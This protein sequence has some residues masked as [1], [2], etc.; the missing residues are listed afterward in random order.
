LSLS[1][2]G[3]VISALV[4]GKGKHIPYRDSKLTRLLQDSLGGNT[5]TLMVAAV[6]P[7]DYNYDE[8]LSTLRYANRAKNIKNK[9]VV[10]EDP[11]DAKLRE[12]KEEIERLKKLLESQSR[13]SV[14]GS[15]SG[16][17]TPT[18]PLSSSSV[19]A[20]PR[21]LNSRGD[22]VDSAN[23][24]K[25]REEIA[26][27][28]QEASAMLDQAKRMMD[29]ARALQAQQQQL[30]E[31]EA[32]QRLQ[33][34][35][36]TGSNVTASERLETSPRPPVSA[37]ASPTMLT[38]SEAETLGSGRPRRPSN[39]PP[40]A[41]PHPPSSEPPPQQEA[42]SSETS[43]SVNLPSSSP[44]AVSPLPPSH[45]PPISP[46]ESAAKAAEDAK[47]AKVLWEAA[48]IDRQA[49]EMMAKAQSMMEAAE[50]R[51]KEPKKVKVVKE[52]VVKEVIPDHHVREK[53]ELREMNQSILV[54]RDRMGKEL[55]RTQE[56]M[57]SYL[58]EKEELRAKLKKIESHI[59]GG[60]SSRQVNEDGEAS[61]TVVDSEIALLKQQ[62]EYRRTQLKL[63]EKARREARH[64]AE[65]K[66]M[67]I[68][69]Q[70]M[71]EELKT[72]QETA[73]TALATAKRKEAKH[74]AKLEAMRQ[75]VADLNNEF[76]REREN[77]LDTIREQTKESKLLEQL[78]EVFLP[79]NELVKVWERAVWSEEREEWTLPRLKPRSDFQ[80]IKLPT[81]PL[82][83]GSTSSGGIESGGAEVVSDDEPANQ[84]GGGGGS[85]RASMSGSRQ[86]QRRNLIPR[87]PTSAVNSSSSKPSSSNEGSVVTSRGQVDITAPRS[88]ATGRGAMP[89][90]NG[91]L[92]SALN[93]GR[94]E[95]PSST[96]G[97]SPS[98][99]SRPDR[100]K[101]KADSISREPSRLAELEPSHALGVLPTGRFYG[102]HHD[103]IA[104]SGAQQLSSGEYQ[105]RDR[106]QSRQGS[107]QGSRQDRARSS[108]S[109]SSSMNP[110]GFDEF[111]ARASPPVASRSGAS[112]TDSRHHRHHR[113]R[114]ESTAQEESGKD[115][116]SLLPLVEASSPEGRSKPAKREKKKKKERREKRED[117][118]PTGDPDASKERGGEQDDMNE[119][120]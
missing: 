14:M 74:R 71:A 8:T 52:V 115:D 55:E 31:A 44:A 76:E 36:Q 68:E 84:P 49:K 45:R 102:A 60:S 12:Y 97:V 81:L 78:V 96:R 90:D 15:A 117:V 46:E 53:E 94:Y 105:P 79:Q 110:D 70:Q 48:Q 40:L 24:A 37:V 107:R 73:Q 98:G 51:V 66:A 58:R 38:T 88:T 41:S 67:A 82:G 87:A 50:A 116:S 19:D 23:I 28:Q 75:E 2:L 85:G 118:S 57:E 113:E 22:S 11:K 65:R 99:A 69:K 114:R 6:S 61:S 16:M 120:W 30:T 56:A 39:L 101:D 20:T 63:K 26:K 27:Y 5:K 47:I 25:E 112:R 72:A 93:S 21:E 111:E 80:K 104:D 32:Q 18:R 4:D 119:D 33:D 62:V 10:N 9:P 92:P 13:G 89:P 100:K 106:L 17:S 7:A 95:S 34:T 54:Q 42:L 103:S 43:S 64:E 109:A 86:Q 83:N 29:E 91:K 108:N 35:T 1:A 59:L 77:L 3:N